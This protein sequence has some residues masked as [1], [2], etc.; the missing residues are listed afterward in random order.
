MD[1]PTDCHRA[2]NRLHIA[3]TGQDFFSLCKRA[4][5]VSDSASASDS[6]SASASDSDSDSKTRIPQQADLTSR[7]EFHTVTVNPLS[8][9]DP[10][11]IFAFN[12]APLSDRQQIGGTH[13]LHTNPT[14]TTTT[15]YF[16][17]EQFNIRFSQGSS[18]PESL[19]PLVE[20]C[21]GSHICGL[22]LV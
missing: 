6:D 18:I 10:R 9:L 16:I 1:I 12:L 7:K 14:H 2:R 19:E 4:S 11:Q 3:L 20:L 5:C 8:R 22:F 15:S 13:L 17:T 21:V